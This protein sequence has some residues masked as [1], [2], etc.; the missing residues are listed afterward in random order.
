[1]SSA[2]FT[3]PPPVQPDSVPVAL[4]FAHNCD[5]RVAVIT[6]NAPEKLNALGWADYKCIT[7]CLEW[8]A[9]QPDILVTIFTGKGRYFSAGANVKDPSRTLPDHVAKADTNTA[10]GKATVADFYGARAQAGQGRLAL[11]LRKHPKI[12]IAALNGPAVGLSA[13]ILSHCDLVYAY[14]DFFLFTPFMSLALVAEGL[15]S[16]TFIKKMGLGRATEALL[17]GRRM[18][19]SD[20]EQSGF[21]TRLYSKPAGF[22]AK[23]KL[24]TPPILDHVLQHV[25]DKFLFPNYSAFSLLYTKKLLNDAAYAYTGL[26]AVNQAELVSDACLCIRILVQR[27]HVQA[28]ADPPCLFS[29]RASCLPQRREVQNPC[30]HQELLR[31]DSKTSPLAHVTSSEAPVEQ[32]STLANTSA[33]ACC[34]PH[35]RTPQRHLSL[36]PAR[37]SL[38]SI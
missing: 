22:H 13:A 1:M 2:K 21:I 8:I 6:L 38:V 31:N 27:N 32:P 14:D 18:T 35:C 30:L 7:Q 11:A 20:L 24:A 37:L 25:R 4:S 3:S 36:L 29:I 5:N 10:H 33:A 17:E 9:L 16:V 23:D 28:E 15:T 12:L 19:A 34:V 26:D